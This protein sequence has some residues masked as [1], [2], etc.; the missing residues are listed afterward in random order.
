MAS[1]RIPTRFFAQRE[2]ALPENGTSKL[3]GVGG[4]PS[5]GAVI[6]LVDEADALAQ[7]REAAK[8][9]YEDRAGVNV[10]IRGVDRLGNARLLVA[11]IM[12][13]SRLD[14]LD[15]AVQRRAVDILSFRRRDR[16]RRR[17]VLGDSLEELGLCLVDAT[18]AADWAAAARDRAER[19]PIASGRGQRGVEDRPEDAPHPA[20]RGSKA[21]RIGATGA[22]GLR[23]RRPMTASRAE[24][25]S[26]RRLSA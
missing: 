14:A 4:E 10:R 19:L 25:I 11:V 3:A 2:H 5:R 6:L 24:L 26:C 12:C 22:F 13:T 20:V 7:S 21:R 15:P 17:A 8:M 18:G 9:H 1:S 23:A 16:G